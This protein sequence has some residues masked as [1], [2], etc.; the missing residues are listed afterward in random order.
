[1]NFVRTKCAIHLASGEY[2][3]VFFQAVR[4]RSLDVSISLYPVSTRQS[5]LTYIFLVFLLAGG[6]DVP[7]PT[8]VWSDG[9]FTPIGNLTSDRFAT[10]LERRCCAVFNALR[11]EN[12]AQD[13]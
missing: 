12:T 8:T 2:L 13:V 5:R 7:H 9:V 4:A 3:R 11:I 1:M 6:G 10:V